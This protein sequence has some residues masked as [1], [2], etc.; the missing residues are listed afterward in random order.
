MISEPI[1]VVLRRHVTSAEG[2]R[3]MYDRLSCPASAGHWQGVID[4][5]NRA[6]EV[7][8]NRQAERERQQ[9][10]PHLSN[11]LTMYSFDYAAAER[12][13]FVCLKRRDD[14]KSRDLYTQG[15]VRL[16]KVPYSKVTPGMRAIVKARMFGNTYGLH[17][18]GSI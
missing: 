8:D 15:A 7:A 18:R 9:K 11:Q 1:Q 17:G 4:G 6:I 10:H 13:V 2:M 3:D 14:R 12:R 5:L 16:F